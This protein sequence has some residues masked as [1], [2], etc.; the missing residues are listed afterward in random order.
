MI[1]T[2]NGPGVRLG[3]RVRAPG[4]GPDRGNLPQK[5]SPDEPLLTIPAGSLTRHTCI[6]GRT[7]AGKSVTA[8]VLASELHSIGGVSVVILDRT[9]RFARS[10]LASLP[11]A[12]VYWPGSNF[13]ISPFARRS[14]NSDDDVERYVSLMHHFVEGTR[15]DRVFS[16]YQESA[17]RDALKTCYGY[18]SSRL[19][20]VLSQLE[21]QGDRCSDSAGG[22]LEGNQAVIS[23]LTPLVSG[24]LSRVFDADA[25]GV[26][27]AELSQPGLRIIN[28]GPLETDEARNMASQ[29]VCRLLIDHGKKLGHTKDLR[30]VLIVDEA[31]HLAPNRRGYEGIVETYGNEVRKYGMGL[32]V[33]A[34][35]PTEISEGIIANSGTILS[36]SMTSGKD[37][38]LALNYMASSLEAERFAAQL[39]ALDAGECLVQLNDRSTVVP[40]RCRIGLPEHGFLLLPLPVPTSVGAGADGPKVDSSLLIEIPGEDSARAIRDKLPVWMRR[41]AKLTADSGGS[42]SRRSLMDAGHTRKQIRQIVRGRYALLEESGPALHLTSLGRKIAKI[43]NELGTVRHRT[44]VINKNQVLR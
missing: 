43:E 12:T 30:S 16:P 21:T 4:A 27:A 35:R 23:R 24:S 31:Q 41:A 40:T 9:G 7:G 29:I 17:L 37:I 32:V 8:M 6:F 26:T 11:R 22:W 2:A 1:E 10:G 39:R 19:S 3:T 42:V 13:T 25:P 36:H 34:T 38:D 15:G 14:D 28:L 33:T 20:D 5:H 18:D 44:E